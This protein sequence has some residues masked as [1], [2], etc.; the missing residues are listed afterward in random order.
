MS[1]SIADNEWVKIEGRSGFKYL[2]YKHSVGSKRVKN[3]HEEHS[4]I[5]AKRMMFF[6]TR[7][8]VNNCHPQ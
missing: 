1:I 6:V 8:V 2:G 5:Y 3:L 7:E 4:G